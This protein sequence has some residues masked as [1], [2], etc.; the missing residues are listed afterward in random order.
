MHYYELSYFYNRKNRGSI[1]IQSGVGRSQC[2]DDDDFLEYLVFLD[3]LTP[4]FAEAVISIEEISQGEYQKKAK[5]GM[6][7]ENIQD[8][9][10]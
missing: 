5:K 1:V 4:K 10:F 3:T 8:K 9:C 6:R 2:C 7:W